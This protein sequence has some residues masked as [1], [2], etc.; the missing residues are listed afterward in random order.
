MSPLHHRCVESS[1]VNSEKEISCVKSISSSGNSELKTA[2]ESI[3]ISPTATHPPIAG[4]PPAGPEELSNKKIL[5]KNLKRKFQEEEEG[6]NKI[7]EFEGSSSP[8]SRKFKLS[9]PSSSTVRSDSLKFGNIKSMFES[10]SKF[11]VRTSSADLMVDNWSQTE[12]EI[13]SGIRGY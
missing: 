5:T 7:V 6:S 8:S 9:K 11:Q 12:R 3:H 10:I 1:Q 2:C 13:E 4:T